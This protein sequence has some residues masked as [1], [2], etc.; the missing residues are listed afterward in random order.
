[1]K[2]SFSFPMLSPPLRFLLSL[3]LFSS[4]ITTNLISQSNSIY[5]GVQTHFGQFY[6]SDMDSLSMT[7]MLDSV[8]QTGINLIRDECYWAD[9]ETSLGVFTFPKQ[10][11][12]Y[13]V[14][15]YQR[16]IEVL[17]ILNYNNPLY[18]PQ[19]GSGIVT[20][21]NRSAFV[22]Y[23]KQVVNR[24]SPMGVKHYEIWNEP[25]IPLFWDPAPGTSEYFNLI[26]AVYPAIKEIDS[27]ITVLACA[28]SPA[29]GNPAP[30]IS[31]LNF[32]GQVF[33]FGGSN[34]MD[35]ISFHLYRVDRSPENWLFNDINSL[36]AIVGQNKELWLTEVGY[37]TSTTWPNL[38]LSNQASYIARLYLLGKSFNKLKSIVYY[39][40]KNDG[41]NPSEPEHNYGLLNFDLSPKLGYKSYRTFN[42]EIE[43]KLFT[44]GSNT[45][46]Y[47]KYTFVDTSG[48]K[49]YAFWNPNTTSLK[50]E[51][52]LKNRLRITDYL[53]NNYYV[54]DRDKN[55][56][57]NYISSPQYFT[58]LDTFPIIDHFDLFPKIDSI[59]VGQKINLKLIAFTQ[60]GEKIYIDSSAVNWSVGDTLGVIDSTG[61]YTALKEGIG[62]VYGAFEGYVTEKTFQ[63]FPQYNSLEIENFN[64]LNAF[65]INTLNLLPGSNLSITDTNY[66][67]FSYSCLVTFSF[68][69]KGIDQHRFL[70]DCNF[71]LLGEP[72]SLY[73]DVYGNGKGHVIQYHFVDADGDLFTINSPP[74]ALLQVYGWKT[75]KVSL[76]GFGSSFNYPAKLK[77][78]ILFTVQNSGLIDSIYSG[79]ILLDNLRIHNGVFTDAENEI[80]TYPEQ[81]I[82]SQNYPNPYN[83]TTRIQ[84]SLSSPQYVTLKVYDI[85]G[86]EIE[87]LVNEEKKAGSYEITWHSK[88]L[89]SGVYFYRIQ[90]GS[91]IASK[92]MLLLK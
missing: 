25:N 36:R 68:K 61:K 64:D 18:A 50:P 48:N 27:S 79:K 58:E 11:D 7:K 20:D 9:V 22:N 86:N 83:L 76:R 37:H 53:G 46:D 4:I 52:F 85:L 89:P 57:V 69:Y 71:A 34:Y 42:Q 10:I 24:Y 40:L 80:E 45:N 65:N 17:M 12:D 72:D 54:Y 33:A 67:T 1:M 47:Y 92:K 38:S 90:A 55:I 82:L 39:D 91:F 59:I 5:S 8:K 19:A 28:T 41:E 49:T 44:N 73:I 31:W 32:I 13:V 78:I 51:I 15:A 63:I 23:C 29:E 74:N 56:Y 16:G 30:F 62:K 26:K 43:N 81:F 21:S 75:V 6:R 35:G 2:A 66:T 70:L 14:N 77:K 3:Y 84:Y 88:S 60:S 87:S